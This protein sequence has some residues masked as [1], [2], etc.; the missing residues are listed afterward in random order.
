MVRLV[1]ARLRTRAAEPSARPIIAAAMAALGQWK[2]PT[3]HRSATAG[4]SSGRPGRRSCAFIAASTPRPKPS[5]RR[6]PSM[7]TK[8]IKVDMLA[9]VEGEGALYV[10]L[11][12]GQVA[13]VKFKIFEPPRFFEA[14]L[15]GRSFEDAPDITARICG[16]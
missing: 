8:T 10:R 9:R 14:L 13:D 7:N 3:P 11:K 1:L 15:R 12:G 6:A 4:S 5:G 2:S 16:I